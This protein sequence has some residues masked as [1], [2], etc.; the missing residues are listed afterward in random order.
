MAG[1][2]LPAGRAGGMP[3]F[4]WLARGAA[5]DGLAHDVLIEAHGD[6]FTTVTPETPAV[7]GS[8]RAPCGC[9]VSRCRA[10]R[11]R[12]P[13][14]SPRDHDPDRQCR[15]VGDIIGRAAA[16]ARRNR[17]VHRRLGTMRHSPYTVATVCRAG[18][19]GP[20]RRDHDGAHHRLCRRDGPEG[21]TG[22]AMGLLGTMSAIGTAL[23]PSL[24]GVLIA[25]LGWRAIFLVNVPL[26]VRLS[27][28][29]SL[30]PRDR[31]TQGR[32][33]VSTAGTLLLAFRSPPMHSR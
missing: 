18:G 19:A 9:P 22:S 12:S 1:S 17:L 10:W 28:R 11:T 20:W 7:A 6:R 31:P 32:G 30:P 24:G 5:P 13:R 29:V 15:R 21:R 27:S 23:G 25:A 2:G 8:A 26:G 14:P 4:A 16:A 33:P 3:S